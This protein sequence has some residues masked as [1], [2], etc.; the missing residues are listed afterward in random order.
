MA[1]RKKL[2]EANKQAYV[3]A[4]D[5]T[6]AQRLLLRSPAVA[7][8]SLQPCWLPSNRIGINVMPEEPTVYPDGLLTPRTSG[9]R[10]TPP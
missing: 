5:P 9:G 7:H 10:T 3:F 4:L 2:A 6:P 8:G 1:K